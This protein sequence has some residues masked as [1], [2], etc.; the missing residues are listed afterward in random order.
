MTGEFI[1][2]PTKLSPGTEHF[3]LMQAEFSFVAEEI[4]LEPTRLILTPT[5]FILLSVG[6]ILMAI[7]IILWSIL[8][9]FWV[10]EIIKNT[11][12]HSLRMVKGGLN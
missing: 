11:L 8:F 10:V 7:K 12:K 5:D 1:L 6:F 2:L 3:C 9:I 4:I